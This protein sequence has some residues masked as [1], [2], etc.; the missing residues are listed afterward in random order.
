MHYQTRGIILRRRKVGEADRLL[1]IYTEKKGKIQVIAKGSRKILSKLAGHIEPFYLS[2]LSIIKGKGLSILAG[3]ELIDSFI[4]LRENDLKTASAY[5][6]CEVLDNLIVGTEPSE[7]I[8]LLLLNTLKN[9]K[10]IDNSLLLRHFEINLLAYLGHKPELD[11]C[12][13]CGK[14]LKVESNYFSNSSGG[15]ICQNC[16]E[17]NADFVKISADTIK[18]LRLLL[19]YKNPMIVEKIKDIPEVE[20][21][22][23]Q[24]ILNYIVYITGKKLKTVHV[25][26]LLK[27]TK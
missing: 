15:V 13:K 14:I 8:F 10:N 11:K 5:Y 26:Y 20:Q 9:L 18:I 6:I 24:I 21:E 25:K 1:T 22:T 2:D 12:V 19:V 16:H 4:N 17:E 23:E 7:E 27:G 3:A